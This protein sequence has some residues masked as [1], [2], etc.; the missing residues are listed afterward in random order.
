[1]K[2]TV[3]VNY[4]G[5][6]F[7][8]IEKFIADLMLYSI[9]QKYRVVWITTEECVE[10]ADY[11][12]LATDERIEK[13]IICKNRR[14]LHLFKRIDASF[15]TDEN[16]LMVSFEPLSYMAV[17]SLREKANV[18]SFNHFY[19]VPHFTGNIY[20][21]DRYFKSSFGQKIAKY[22]FSRI[23]TK[24]INN[25][26]ILAFGTAHFIE[27]HKQYN[28]DIEN[29]NYQ[30]KVVKNISTETIEDVESI[31]QKARNR[32]KYVEIIT[33]ARFD[34]PHKGYI[35]GLI[36][37]FETLKTAYPML[38]LTIVG[39]GAGSDM[40]NEA[41]AKISPDARSDVELTGALNPVEL[42]KRFRK[43]TI[44]IGVAGALST[45][46]RCGLVSFPARHYTFDCETYG[47]YEDNTDKTL[48]SEKGSDIKIYVAQ[49][50][51]M[52]DEEY[53][54]HCLSASK[55][56]N[57][58]VSV[59][60]EY[61]FKQKNNKLYSKFSWAELLWARYVNTYSLLKYYIFR[62]SETD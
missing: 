7:G 45:G 46:A 44:N 61:L 60:P 52:S 19:I 36:H 21:V 35:I 42:L 13:I 37:E 26:S 57:K 11:K 34:F 3:V 32:D 48:S 49:V 59:D 12:E 47:Y 4:P 43:A 17:D 56:G 25:G 6:K 41:L 31:W 20:F 24:M 16:V 51:S 22:C 29:Y 10:F 33:C 9:S 55:A 40:V 5:L 54:K 62:K 58:L 30:N 14:R 18:E 53:V 15:E 2:K 38:K 39:D 23:L 8:G 50:M 27:Y 1:M 28:L